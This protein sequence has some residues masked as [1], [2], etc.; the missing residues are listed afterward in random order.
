[1]GPWAK[2]A[3]AG[4]FRLHLCSVGAAP[5]CA[6]WGGAGTGIWVPSCSLA[7]HR[8]ATPLQ[9]ARFSGPRK[10]T[11][12]A[13]D[14]SIDNIGSQARSVTCSLDRGDG[15]LEGWKEEGSSLHP[16]KDRL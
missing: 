3:A 2:A 15:W 7:L 14:R 1:M 10:D 8:L 9:D 5:E 13:L 16:W 4:R 6:D 12:P 11:A